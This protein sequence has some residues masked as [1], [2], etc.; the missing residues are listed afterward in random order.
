MSWDSLTE[1]EKL[2]AMVT[3]AA[4][5]TMIHYGLWFSEAVNQFGLEQALKDE[6]VAG[7]R[8]LK[9]LMNR[10]SKSVGLELK[11]GLPAALA[12]MDEERL[13]ALLEGLS[14][15]WLAF[16]GVWF[17]SVE[18]RRPGQL[19]M[20]AAK[21]TNDTCWSKFA[22]YEASRIMAL[23]GLPENG[24]LETLKTALGLRLY[25]RINKQEIVEETDNSFVFRM[26]VCRVQAARRRKGLADYPCKS[27][28]TVEYT[29][30]ARTIDPRI[31]TECIGCPPDDH[32]DNW[33]CA[34]KFTLED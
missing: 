11:D 12:D 3:D 19:G 24:G 28:G 22:P 30:F 7:D 1:K 4:R 26:N 33:F 34:W 5:R 9:F 27:G 31:K 2:L 13:T 23:A 25:S 18:G 6:R 32:P 21:R 8:A 16:D 29:T 14:A 10:L 20:D 17:Q 15:N